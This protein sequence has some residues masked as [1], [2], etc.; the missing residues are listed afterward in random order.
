MGS[1]MCIR[2]RSELAHSPHA[3]ALILVTH[4]LEEIPPGFTHV[5]MLKDGEVTAKGSIEDTL[6]EENLKKT[7]GVDVKLTRTEQGRYSAF[8]R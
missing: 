8:A 6:T 5:L 4:H 2:D 3:P 1:E 7:F